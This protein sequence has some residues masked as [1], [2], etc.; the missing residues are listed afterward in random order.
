MSDT[1]TRVIVCVLVTRRGAPSNNTTHVVRLSTFFSSISPVHVSYSKRTN[2][3]V[4]FLTTFSSDEIKDADKP[5]TFQ[6]HQCNIQFSN[7]FLMNS[8]HKV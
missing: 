7:E 8:P 4:Y 2:R 6:T 5:V 1:E 3:V